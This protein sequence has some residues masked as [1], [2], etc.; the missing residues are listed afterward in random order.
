MSV[1]INCYKSLIKPVLEYACTV[2]AP[3]TQKDHISAI[4]SVQ[5]HAA[6]FIIP[7]MQVLLRC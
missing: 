5:R 6:R 2:W 4:E 1:K 3:H 7:P